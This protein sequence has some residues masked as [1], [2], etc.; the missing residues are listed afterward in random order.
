M[1]RSGR[2]K[3]FIFNWRQLLFGLNL[4]HLKK[5][6]PVWPRARSSGV[7]SAS[8]CCSSRCRSW[9]GSQLFQEKTWSCFMFSTPWLWRF[10]SKTARKTRWTW[11]RR[12]LKTDTPDHLKLNVLR[13]LRCSVSAHTQT[14][15]VVFDWVLNPFTFQ[16][17]DSRRVCWSSS[18][19]FLFPLSF[20]LHTDSRTV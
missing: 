9:R 13:R 16:S 15:R 8:H 7:E 1:S 19:L 10:S 5:W 11:G 18:G 12:L 2:K 3:N 17:L 6:A 20:L 14:K 4:F